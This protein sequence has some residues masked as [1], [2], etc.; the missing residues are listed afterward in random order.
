MVAKEQRNTGAFH[1]E[2]ALAPVEEPWPPRFTPGRRSQRLKRMFDLALVGLGLPILLPVG[3]ALAGWIRMDSPGPVIYRQRRIGK[4]GHPFTLFKF[5]SMIA[6]ADRYAGP[7]RNDRDGPAFK[8]RNDPRITRAGRFLRRYSLD[9]LP[10]LYNVLREEMSLI[11]PRPMLEAELRTLPKRDLERLAVK[12]GISGPWQVSGRALVD[13]STWMALDRDTFGMAR[14]R[15]HTH[16]GPNPLACGRYGR[17][18]QIPSKEFCRKSDNV[19]L[20]GQASRRARQT[21][22]SRRETARF[23]QR[24]RYYFYYSGNEI[25][26]DCRHPR[27]GVQFPVS[28]GFACGENGRRYKQLPVIERMCMKVLCRKRTDRNVR[29]YQRFWG[30][31]FFRYGLPLKIK[32]EF[33][34]PND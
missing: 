2:P 1:P 15:D 21:D 12:P 4:D 25:E 31:L 9:E 33:Y 18:I 24:L 14:C 8:M 28:F 17:M 16:G 10:Q 34:T 5:R 20:G 23:M 11:G 3:L 13:F 19:S 6:D 7:L 22:P 32:S 27:S 29:S 26:P 30:T